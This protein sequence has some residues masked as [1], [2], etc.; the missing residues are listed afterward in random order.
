[1]NELRLWSGYISCN[2]DITLTYNCRLV[3][4]RSSSAFLS[5]LLPASMQIEIPDFDD[6][7]PAQNYGAFS[8]SALS[9]RR[10]GS[11]SSNHQVNLTSGFSFPNFTTSSNLSASRPFG[12]QQSYPTPTAAPLSR[13]PSATS[14]IPSSTIAIH[15][16]SSSTSLVLRRNPST[17]HHPPI[18]ASPSS[19]SLNASYHNPAPPHTTS[20]TAHR[21]LSV[22]SLRSGINSKSTPNSDNSRPQQQ[23]HINDQIPNP[24]A[25]INNQHASGSSPVSAGTQNGRFPRA[26]SDTKTANAPNSTGS[27]HVDHHAP[28]E[29]AIYLIM[30]RFVE[31]C[32][33]K[34]AQLLS[35]PIPISVE[36]DVY[37]PYCLGPGVDPAFDATF[38]SLAQVSKKNPGQ[39][40]NFVMRWKSRQGETNDDY[41]IQRAL[42]TSGNSLNARR[43]A[44]VL[45]ERKS[46]ALVYILCRALIS[47]VQVVT[48]EALGEELGARLEEIIFNSI[49]NAD[50]HVTSR[51]PNKQANMNMFAYLLGVLSNIRFTSVSDR[52]ASEIDAMSRVTHLRDQKDGEAK[53]G[54]LIRGVQFLKLKVYPLEAF[55]DTADFISVFATAFES[56]RGSFVKT[57]MAE[58]LGPLLVQVV[59]TATAEVNHP[60]WGK[61]INLILNKSHSISDKPSKSRYWNSTVPLMCA[62]VGAA[63][64]EALLPKW[65]DTVDWCIAKLKEKSTRATVMLGIVRL[66]WSYLHRV[67]EGA[68]AL[69]KRLEP[70]LKTAFPPDRKNV[71]PSEVSLDTFAS[72][73]HF[74]LYWQLDYGTDFVLRSLLTYANDAHDNN[75]GLVA[76]T[77]AERIMI[78]ITGSL[79]ALTSLEKG[80]DPPY[81][82]NDN[83]QSSQNSS[84]PHNTYD[85]NYTRSTD[86]PNDG[87]ALK[88]ELLEKPRIKAFVD[89]IGTK[90]LQM[91]AYCDRTLAPFTTNE[92]KYLTPWHDNI[93][94]RVDV[95]DGP[96]VIK[97]HGAF[98]V[99]YPRHLQPTFDVLQTC[100]QAWPRI[101]NSPAS[102][103][104]ALAILLKGLVSLDVGVTIEAKLCLRRFLQAGKSFTVLQVY[105]R[106]LVKPEFWVRIKPQLQKGLDSKV[107]NLVK[108]W[109]EALTAWCEH[110]RKVSVNGEDPSFASQP[111]F[112]PDG[113]KLLC[114]M[115]AVALVLLCSRSYYIRRSALD[116]L[117][118]I[119][120]ARGIIQEANSTAT[121]RSLN[122]DPSC[123]VTSL[124]AEAEKRLFDNLNVDDFSSVE[125]NRLVKWKKHRKSANGESL[126]RLLESDNHADNTLLCFALSSIFG[127]S[128]VHLPAIVSHARTLLYGQLQRLYPLASDAA[129]VGGRSTVN[130]TGLNP[131]W[132]DRNL[133][134]SWSSLLISVTSITT[135]TDPKTGNLSPTIDTLSNTAQSASARERNISPGED[136][137]KTLVPFLTSD[138]PPFREAAIRA[139]SSVH[140]SMYPTLLEGLS[141]LAHH[142][143]SERKMIEAQ[144]DRSARPNGTVKIIRLFS[145]IGKLH[146]S[147]TKL[148]FHPDFNITER[149]ID[150]L[151]KFTRE[152]CIFL[153]SQQ[154]IEDIVTIS[155]RKS[156]L[157]F[158]EGLLR[159]VAILRSSAN[160]EPGLKAQISPLFPKELFLDFYNIAEDLSTRAISGFHTQFSSSH[161][162]LTYSNNPNFPSGNDGHHS[163]TG[164]SSSKANVPARGRP[165]VSSTTITGDLL[166][167]SSTMVA[168]LCESYLDV[169]VGSASQSK[170]DSNADR[171]R[172]SSSRILRWIVMI[173]E[174]NDHKSH[175]QARR[176][177]IGSVR[178]SSESDRLLEATLALCWNESKSITLLQTLFSVLGSALISEPTLH[179][180]DSALLVICLARLT[181]SDLTMR[182]QAIDLLRARGML[183]AQPDLLS[184]VE[185]NLA[186]AFA[187]QHLAAQARTSAAVCSLRKVDPA[188]F[189]LE[190]G[191][192]IIQTDPQK[193]KPFARMMPNWLNQIHLPTSIPDSASSKFRNLVNV[194]L[195]VTSKI[196]DSQPDEVRSIWISLA[197][198]SPPNSKA[199]ATYL[200]GQTARRGL[201]AFVG[202]V[203]IL[204]SCMSH[205]DATDAIQK[206]L[207]G[208]VEP[209]KL[210]AASTPISLTDPGPTSSSGSRSFDLDTCF[211]ALSSRA[212]CSPMQAVILLL[213]ETMVI[214]PLTLGDRLAHI[215]HAYV[216]QVDHTN[217]PFRA[218]MQEGLVR[219]IGMLRR[220]RNPNDQ[221]SGFWDDN[222]ESESWRSFWEFDDLGGSRRHRKGPPANMES[223]VHLIASLSSHLIPDF[224]RNWTQVAVE[225]ATQCPVR[226]IAC[227]S[228]QVVRVLGLPVDPPLLAELLVRLS[229][230]ASDPS[231]DIQLF[232]LEVL[233]TYSDCA[234][235]ATGSSALYAQLFWTG[236]SCLETAN[237]LEF[238]ESIELI[239]SLVKLIEPGHC[240]EIANSRP[241][242]WEP[243]ASPFR[244]LLIKGLRSS[245]LCSASWSLVKDLLDLPENC[246]I[247]DWLNG[248]LALLY[249]A[250]LPWCFHVL[251]TGVMQYEIDEIALHVG[252]IAESFRMEGLSRVMVSFAKN[253]FRTK[254]DFLRQAVNG[255]REYFLPKF[256]ADILVVYLGLLCNPLEWL[257]VKTLAVLK[258]FLKTIEPTFS[259]SG[260]SDLG[261]D[262]LT[263]LLHLLQTNASQQALD[264]LAEPMPI[265]SRPLNARK[266]FASSDD[267]LSK[268]VFGTPDETG[269]CVPSP[270]EA[271]RITRIRL[272]DVIDTF[273]TSFMSE[274]LNRSSV[275]EFTYDWGHE[276]DNSIDAQTQ[277][278]FA[279]TNE[280]F[281]DMVSTLHDLSDF[282]GQD[283]GNGTALG[284]SS[285]ISSPLN[286]STARVAAILSRS[287]S[288]RRANRPSLHVRPSSGTQRPESSH[289][290]QINHNSS[291]SLLGLSSSSR[292]L[293]VISSS[294]SSS[295]RRKQAP[296]EYA[297]HKP[298]LSLDSRDDSLDLDDTTP[299]EDD[300][301]DCD[302]DDDD[303]EDEEDEE[304]D[305]HSMSTGNF[306]GLLGSHH[307]PVQPHIALGRASPSGTYCTDDS[308]SVFGFELDNDQH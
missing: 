238:L 229:N 112:G 64:Q 291:S 50:P 140:V 158:G 143:T 203:R 123:S 274:S 278:D 21:K 285:R 147:T 36:D 237:D 9:H 111:S 52:F 3:D 207:M 106:F 63:P 259:S 258:L 102:E 227:R 260:I 204:L 78:G 104:A 167:A 298:S 214:R 73:I 69:N 180:R 283:G 31:E 51:T 245:Q 72:L 236:V 257:R 132:D 248:G 135:S 181:H 121:P 155:I 268:K 304:E 282:F 212:V 60:V 272:T 99:E 189:V 11:N 76:Q 6:D 59:Q 202:L 47:V 57:T 306:T 97:R 114:F 265:K 208:L 182:Q 84:N 19:P 27:A 198:A 205:D 233:T 176:A 109:V 191:S 2:P 131:G 295:P 169:R 261:Y 29:V 247:I 98:A 20:R 299:N 196:I 45:S 56:S 87:Q 15:D 23:R 105:T 216:V 124:L 81:P 65:T 246:G 244:P 275:V 193:S 79:R 173:F 194:V 74:I 253:R 61:A 17:T 270:Q 307:R 44:A 157:T 302:E 271:M 177:F 68:S 142:L 256:S 224:S 107:E 276:A 35:K 160:L 281:G 305:R 168:T 138:Q 232:A 241:S 267:G 215:L 165:S 284:S 141:G 228:L 92:D 219:F 94:S 211:P 55:E 250:C 225:W 108:F 170:S 113:T 263:P 185:V 24:S 4:G 183:S 48:R 161:L 297:H 184:D 53:L 220:A 12:G 266:V 22:A 218:Q 134:M 162:N 290:P 210:L 255:I 288:K 186:S 100:L 301:D 222:S 251:E 243:D 230:T 179:I 127:I 46:L 7:L 287:L 125:R 43:V 62:A 156:F 296:V 54:N 130:G 122:F 89:A 308:Q 40:V 129:G 71:Y 163:R 103:S 42:V 37:I 5:S 172:I 66:T 126:T 83:H 188:E 93:A 292:P 33:S 152:T 85:P 213:G 286:P 192:R 14:N 133:Y 70:I 115:E 95:F 174:K 239:R 13:R 171:P 175:M 88:A 242:H 25:G 150:I 82:T 249:A 279:E 289:A 209:T 1:M 144:K 303:N 30:D 18:H 136:L 10:D 139:M 118:I 221:P 226:H 206:D 67:R 264:I 90:V 280:S 294:G 199:I 200:V 273:A 166:P 86:S 293:S 110:I 159:K 269:W 252:R 101:L 178:S 277:S 231:Q 26:R 77:G 137:I 240:Y 34:L 153:K 39:V 300:D 80:E 8:S 128:L 75:Q 145:A 58:T 28:L 146:E 197:N 254:E 187:G 116:A 119:A 96:T 151:C 234:K 38:V 49:K 262:L 117:R 190:L 149:T 217:P 164:S 195:L 154:N 120:T 148:L 91:A 201:P 16:Q 235:I 32:E 223:L 41:A